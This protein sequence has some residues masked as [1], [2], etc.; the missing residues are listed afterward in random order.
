MSNRRDFLTKALP[1]CAVSCLGCRAA[2]SQ[3]KFQETCG[4]SYERVFQFAFRDNFIPTLNALAEEIGR[5]KF[6]AM[7][8]RAASRVGARATAERAAKSPK[9]D[10]AAWAEP[11]VHP[12]DL[13]QHLLTFKI[14][15]HTERAIEIKVTECLWAKTFRDN[16]AAELGHAAICQPD[17]ATAPAFNPKL[18]MVRT[19]TLMQ[20][21]ECCNHRWEMES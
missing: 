11:L 18:K 21:H 17:F 13:N 9:R 3:H 15:E 10:L 4:L 19:K 8:E 2:A 5:D 14:V 6:L 16:G 20:G 12:S 7:V 1:M